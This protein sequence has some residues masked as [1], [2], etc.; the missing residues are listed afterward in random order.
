MC[1]GIVCEPG[2]DAMN[3]EVNLIFLIKLFFMHDQNAVTKTE[4]SRERKKLLRQNKKHFSS[5][6]KG[7]QSSK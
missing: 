5:F 7:F 3:F 6:L 1:I 2:C 4:I